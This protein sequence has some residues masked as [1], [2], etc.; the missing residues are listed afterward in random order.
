MCQVFLGDDI[1]QPDYDWDKKG[2]L[3]FR[4]FYPF[5]PKGII[6]R[7]IVRLHKNIKYQNSKGLVW[8]TGVVLEKNGCIAKVEEIKIPTTGQQ[9]I[10]IEVT[11]LPA[12]RKLLLYD[13]CSTIE[14]IHKDSFSKIMFE[15][16]IPCNCDHCKSLEQPGFY[17]YSE[18]VDYLNE[19][20]EKIRCKLKVKN[21]LPVR[22]L[23]QYIFDVDFTK[24]DYINHLDVKKEIV[25]EILFNDPFGI[26]KTE[27][28]R[29]LS[30]T[31]KKI[32]VFNLPMVY[33]LIL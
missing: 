7:L 15:R 31:H 6:T 28:R 26:N 3:H 11:G 21:E 30:L 27:K 4:Y 33:N 9:V 5:I 8:R 25:S 10:A 32:P 16:Q 24:L 19:G 14:G 29:Y 13:I 17:D 22:L 18:L 1:L 2:G 23:L 20:I 12:N